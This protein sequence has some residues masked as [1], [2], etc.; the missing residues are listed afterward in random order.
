[1]ILPGF[2]PRGGVQSIHLARALP[3]S[4]H[5][6]GALPAGAGGNGAQGAGEDRNRKAAS[7]Q[8]EVRA[9]PSDLL[10]RLRRP[11]PE[12]TVVSER[13]ARSGLALRQQAGEKEVWHRLPI[14][15]TVRNGPARGSHHGF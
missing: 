4:Y 1:M 5:S 2:T 10:L 15:H 8:R 12:N 9:F 7:L 3:R 6:S 14:T 11:L 13:R